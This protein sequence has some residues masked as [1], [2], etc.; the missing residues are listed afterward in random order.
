LSL[1]DK[2]TV[3]FLSYW[4]DD[5]AGQVFCLARRRRARTSRPSTRSPT[6]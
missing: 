3:H 2:H 6:G 5:E 1:A 4:F